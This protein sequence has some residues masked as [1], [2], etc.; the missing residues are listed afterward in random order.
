M[1]LIIGHTGSGKTAK[2]I[3]VGLKLAEAGKRVLFFDGESSAEHYLKS[4][5]DNQKLP[6]GF[7][8]FDKFSKVQDIYSKIEYGGYDVYVIDTPN[9][10][11]DLEKLHKMTTSSSLYFVLGLESNI[12]P[13]L[14]KDMVIITSYDELK[15]MFSN[16]V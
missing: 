5:L 4:R 10:Y 6:V 12:F 8:I 2:A 15:S 1:K 11:F 9:L 3:K 14:N 16:R 7:N 13:E